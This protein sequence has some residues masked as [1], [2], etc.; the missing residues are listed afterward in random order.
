MELTARK[1]SEGGKSVK[2]LRAEGLIPAELYGRGIENAHLIVEESEFRKVFRE[3]GENTVIDL[4]VD[5]EKRKVLIHDVQRHYLKGTIL[6]VDFYQIREDEKVTARVPLKFRGESPAVKE[7]GALLNKAITEV[8]VRALPGDLPKE[9]D[10]D[11]AALDE[12]DKSIYIR[13]L[14]IPR[15]VEITL[16]PDTVVAT[17]MEREPEQEE[18]KQESEEAAKEQ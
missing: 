8:E 3:A 13:D 10:V 4:I 16:D 15:G 9:I 7:K 1:R 12:V 2:L 11:L 6:H 17:A 5:G 18:S 14:S